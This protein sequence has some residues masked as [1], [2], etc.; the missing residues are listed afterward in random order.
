MSQAGGTAE[1][2]ASVF[3]AATNIDTLIRLGVVD[4][5]E[6]A[7]ETLGRAQKPLLQQY[8]DAT[9]K[10]IDIAAAFDHSTDS[11]IALSEALTA[12]KNVALDLALAYKAA[13]EVITGTFQSATEYITEAVLDDEALYGRRREQIATLTAEL[14]TTI[15]PARISEIVTTVDRLAR[16]AFGLLDETQRAVVAP[17]F[18]RFIEDARA[19]AEERVAAGE[20]DLI[21]REGATSAV[22]NLEI[23]RT[24]ATTYSTATTAFAASVD[25]FVAAVPQW[26]SLPETIKAAVASYQA[27]VFSVRRSEVNAIV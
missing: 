1:Q 13:G 5:I 6:D 11:I 21:A 12:Q 8:D 23:M 2:I 22:L 25:A 14:E 27:P 19:L 9:E 7:L 26:A 20:A 4:Q 10:V 17:E 3:V 18:I 24:S 15:D 16:A